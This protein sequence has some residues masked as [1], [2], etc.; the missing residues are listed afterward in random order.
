NT[1]NRA[2]NAPLHTVLGRFQG[3]A[4]IAW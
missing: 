4:L 1:E 2:E 3:I